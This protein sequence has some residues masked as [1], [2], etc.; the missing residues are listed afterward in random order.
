MQINESMLGVHASA[1]IGHTIL[2]YF[3]PWNSLRNEKELSP[4]PKKKNKQTNKKKT[5]NNNNNKNNNKTNKQ[6][7]K[8][9][10]KI[11][12]VTTITKFKTQ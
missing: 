10:T 1:A 6:T 12:N 7:N 2:I 9:K 5:K 4:P 3:F 8:K 11:K